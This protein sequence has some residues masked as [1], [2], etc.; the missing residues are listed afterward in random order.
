[1]WPSPVVALNRA[2]ALA[3]VDGPGA[4]LAAIDALDDPRLAGYRYLPAVRADLLRRLGRTAEAAAEY[5]R[6][7]ALTDNDVERRFLSER[8][9]RP[10]P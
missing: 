1:V 10:A 2:V 8:L 6:A 7:I 9:A 4:A 5:S 3:E